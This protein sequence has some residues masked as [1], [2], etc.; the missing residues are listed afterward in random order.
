MH[1]HGSSVALLP[2]EHAEHQRIRNVQHRDLVGR[3]RNKAPPGLL[4][5]DSFQTV[6]SWIV[7]VGY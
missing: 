6:L 7:D 1:N 4:G 2:E 5:A 3:T